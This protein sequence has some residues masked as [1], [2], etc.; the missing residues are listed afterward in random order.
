MSR[1]IMMMKIR[2]KKPE[3]KPVEVNENPL[4]AKASDNFTKSPV[5]K[6]YQ[7]RSKEI[8][9]VDI[10]D[11]ACA[12]FGVRHGDMAKDPNGDTCKIVGVAF[13]NSLWYLPEG[14]SGIV[15][16]NKTKKGDFEVINEPDNFTKSPVMKEFVTGTGKTIEVDISDEACAEFGVKHGDRVKS[17][18]GG[19]AV[20]AGVT[21]GEGSRYND[22]QLWY[23]R[24]GSFSDLSYWG[25]AKK[26]EFKIIK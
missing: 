20:V 1:K 19:N 13:G 10:S 9:D 7:A 18:A 25:G 21:I 4:A 14:E 5:M 15:Y 23:S 8:I 22:N 3:K 24:N 6:K 16:Y 2:D 11:E 26:G 12:E 17:P